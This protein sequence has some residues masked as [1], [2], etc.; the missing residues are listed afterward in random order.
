M[1]DL[2]KD[3]VMTYG[4]LKK[5]V[6]YK[7]KGTNLKKCLALYLLRFKYRN[8]YGTINGDYGVESEFNYDYPKNLVDELD[9]PVGKYGFVNVE[10]SKELKSS[11]T[12][13]DRVEDIDIYS[14]I[15]INLDKH[16]KE[17]MIKYLNELFDIVNERTDFT[18]I[19]YCHERDLFLKAKP[20]LVGDKEMDSKFIYETKGS[21]Y[22]RGTE[23]I[24]LETVGYNH[25]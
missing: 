13:S 21:K 22:I 12:V 17:D 16:Q 18:L 8:T 23:D 25:I 9:V 3:Y 4:D 2:S 1:R 5:L 19:D 11:E 14:D 24:L 20:Y 6:N 15:F 7:V 10:L